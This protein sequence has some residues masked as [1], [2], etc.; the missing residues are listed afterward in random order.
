MNRQNIIEQ[1]NKIFRDIFND[2]NII[3][4]KETTAVDIERW[5]SLSNV[6]LVMTI[7]RT[8]KI[9]FALGELQQLKNVGDMIEILERRINH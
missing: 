5:D 9:S 4:S 1:L 8:F 7:E 3:V 6:N 2:Q